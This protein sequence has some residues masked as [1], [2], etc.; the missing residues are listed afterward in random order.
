MNILNLCIK[1]EGQIERF[2]R[3]TTLLSYDLNNIDLQVELLK[4]HYEIRETRLEMRK[5]LMCD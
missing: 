4:L 5:R 1:Y 2:H 3:L